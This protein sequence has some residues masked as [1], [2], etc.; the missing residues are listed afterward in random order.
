ML[1]I[2]VSSSVA[3]I[4]LPS[5]KVTVSVNVALFVF[6]FKPLKYCKDVEIQP[7]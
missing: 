6:A 7:F 1:A 4:A 5:G 3:D 2:V